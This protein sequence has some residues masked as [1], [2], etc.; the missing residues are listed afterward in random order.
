VAESSPPLIGLLKKATPAQAMVAVKAE[1]AKRSFA[2]FVKQ[3]WHIFHGPEEPLVWTWHLQV[4]CDHLQAVS[5]GR[6]LNLL[7]NVP[8]GMGKSLLASVFWPAWEWIKRPWL[9]YLCVTGTSKVMLRDAIKCR[10]VVDSEWY[11]SSF[12][13]TWTWSK[14]QDAKTYYQNTAGGGRLSSTTRQKITGVRPHRRIGDDLLD[15]DEAY[16]DKAALAAVNAWYDQSYSTRNA[17]KQSA[18]VMIGQRL[19][20]MDPP[21]HVMKMERE[22]WVVLC[23]PNEYTGKKHQNQLGYEDPRTVVGELLFPYLCDEQAT[24]RWK[25]KLGEAG[26]SAKYQQEPTPE[27]GNIFQRDDLEAAAWLLGDELPGFDYMIGSWDLNNLKKPKPT[28]D[29]DFVCGDLWGVKG[30]GQEA[31]RWLLKQYREKIGLGEQIEQIKAQRIAYPKITHTLIEAKA[32]GPAVIAAIAGQV[33]GIEP[34]NVQGESKIQR[35]TAI[36][37]HVQAGR[38]H[39]PDQATAPW[40]REWLAEVCGFPGLRLDDRVDTLTMANIWIDSYQGSNGLWS[41]VIG[42]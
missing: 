18:E 22:K 10:E 16:G 7:I 11:Q 3:A 31:H 25:V 12:R 15:A 36:T 37:H 41:A 30:E 40:V 32:N 34:I 42:G 39:P 35:A 9:T 13:P 4:I 33:E 23:L 17:N 21:G 29:T 1:L 20:E 14:R 38:I 6:A 19:H 27:L 24:A 28:T 8:P 26:Y 2:E 5:E